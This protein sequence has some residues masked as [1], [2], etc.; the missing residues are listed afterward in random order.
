MSMTTQDI[1]QTAGAKFSIE[2]QK[3]SLKNI[4]I[5]GKMWGK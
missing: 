2:Y 1:S 5:K 3:I 4:H